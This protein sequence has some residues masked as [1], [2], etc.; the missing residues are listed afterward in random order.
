MGLPRS[1]RFKTAHAMAAIAVVGLFLG[2]Q[3]VLTYR[4]ERLRS[5]IA[6]EGWSASGLRLSGG[7]LLQLPGF[8]VLPVAS[9]ALSETTKRGVEIGCDGRVYGLLRVH[10][11]CG[12]DTRLEHVAR[13]DIALLL[14]FLEEGTSSEPIPPPTWSHPNAAGAF[15]SA[16]WRVE[17][18]NGF[19]S[20]RKSIAPD[21]KLERI[22]P[23]A[24]ESA[25][26]GRRPSVPVR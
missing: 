5:P 22:K 19:E 11:L 7:G 4:V 16:G 24:A 8:S 12:N 13:V 3:R 15:S 21:V 25:T 26:I 2:Y 23:A 6:I 10:H 1:L 20:W 14:I 18:F 9:A 17:E